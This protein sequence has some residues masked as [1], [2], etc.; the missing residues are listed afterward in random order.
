[1]SN[2][3]PVPGS[4]EGHSRT[5]G[6]VL[7]SWI[8]STR[9]T[10]AYYLERILM[11]TFG[12]RGFLDLSTML[13][14]LTVHIIDVGAA[15]GFAGR[16]EQFGNNLDITLFEPNDEAYQQLMAQYQGDSRVRCLNTALSEKDAKLNI[17]ITAYPRASS[18]YQTNSELTGR[19]FIRDHFQVVKVVELDARRLGDLV[20]SADFIKIDT[21]G[22]ELPVL[23]GAEELLDSCIGLEVEVYFNHLRNN[24]PLFGD[25]DKYCR[26]KGFTLIEL[27]KPGYRHYL[28]P[29]SQLESKGFIAA[30][31]ALYFRLPS[32]IVEFVH[33][34]KWGI[35]RIAVASSLYLAYGNYEFAHILIE[36]AV[37]RSLISREDHL[38]QSIRALI[39]QRSGYGGLL[40]Y[41]SIKRL[42]GF[43]SGVTEHEQLGF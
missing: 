24:N 6:E 40:S 31:D 13:G 43:I 21:E 15:G 35:E 8:H 5:R 16:W 30:S 29:S 28:L 10:G 9:R 1:M 41:R 7:G 26:E 39:R 23:R 4:H 25:V 18:I 36:D 27:R 38:Y 14:D 12:I 32:D 20:E 11:K 17:H 34:G 33:S 22:H 3:Q 37:D 42:S 2:L 19:S